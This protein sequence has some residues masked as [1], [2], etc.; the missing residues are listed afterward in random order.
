MLGKTMKKPAEGMIS[1]SLLR[2]VIYRILLLLATILGLFWYCQHHYVKLHP[3]YRLFSL[4]ADQF[5]L[6]AAQTLG[7]GRTLTRDQFQGFSSKE[8]WWLPSFCRH[9]LEPNQTWLSVWVKK[10]ARLGFSL[11]TPSI[12]FLRIW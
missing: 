12:Y 7:K 2:K 9:K 4:L 5:L 10:S 8:S 11:W 3:I 1:R 6:A